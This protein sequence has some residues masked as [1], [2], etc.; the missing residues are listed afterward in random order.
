MPEIQRES[1]EYVWIPITASWGDLSDISSVEVAITADLATRPVS[2]VS[3]TV[4]GPADAMGDGEN[5]YIRTLIGADGDATAELTHSGVGDYQLW[6]R[7][8]ATPEQIVLAE[9][10]VTVL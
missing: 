7:L 6:E 2:W 1:R 9:G 10:T 3:A 8:S 5:T 4:V